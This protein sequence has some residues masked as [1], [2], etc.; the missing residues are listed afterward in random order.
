MPEDKTQDALLEALEAEDFDRARANLKE[1]HPSEVA[2][3]L[4]SQP[5]KIRE[6]IWDMV[7]AELE[8]DVLSHAQDAVRAG[9]LE[10]MAPQEVAE[11]TRELDVDDAA[12]ILHDL[13]EDQASY[14]TKTIYC[15]SSGH[16]LM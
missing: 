6:K 13:P 4:E 16:Y 7:P 14:T 10:T 1:L 9:L 11:A 12:D 2:D 8:G 15:Y 5:S 3:L